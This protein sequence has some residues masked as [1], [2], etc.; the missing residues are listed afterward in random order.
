MKRRKEKYQICRIL[1]LLESQQETPAM[2]KK[3]VPLL[4]TSE[5]CMNILLKHK[6]RIMKK[7]KLQLKVFKSKEEQKQDQE[8]EKLD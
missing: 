3:V 7:K 4:K 2:R 1:L 6:E 8:Q 5:H